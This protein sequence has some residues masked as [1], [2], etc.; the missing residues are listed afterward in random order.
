M[1]AD[2][3]SGRL[4]QR[5]EEFRDR[6]V[7][8]FDAHFHHI[9]RFLDRMSGDPDLAADLAQETFIRLFRRGA[10]PDSPEAWLITVAMNLFRNAST[11]K[12]RRKRLLAGRAGRIWHGDPPPS[13]ERELEGDRTRHRV[14]AA[15]DRL[16]E[17]ERSLLL[18]RAEGYSYRDLGRAL[19]IKDASVGKLLSR[20]RERF[21]ETYGDDR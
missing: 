21:R 1:P 4:S 12:A 8:L 20:A 15:L 2:G 3:R 17:R 5:R 6:F 19:G 10:V 16:S 13:P 14:R 18:L 11:R 7:R 9:L